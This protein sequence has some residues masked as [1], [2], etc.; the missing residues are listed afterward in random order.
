MSQVRDGPALRVGTKKGRAPSQ[1]PAR[2][3]GESCWYLGVSS[4][5]DALVHPLG[6]VGLQPDD[7]VRTD[8]DLLGELTCCHPSVCGGA[9]D[10]DAIQDFRDAEEAWCCGLS[11]HQFCSSL[12][13]R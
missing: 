1:C 2:G 6:D 10:A 5:P 7:G 3:L 11:R 4:R 8:G 12:R 13:A 9:T